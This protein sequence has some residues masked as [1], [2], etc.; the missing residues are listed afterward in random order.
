MNRDTTTRNGKMINVRQ[1]AAL[2]GKSAS[3]VYKY[4]ALL[5]HYRIGSSIL[6]DKD[7]IINFLSTHREEDLNAK[8][9]GNEKIN[10]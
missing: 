2:I 9:L 4:R 5:P 10:Y 3:W 7:E 8:N 1:C 6:F